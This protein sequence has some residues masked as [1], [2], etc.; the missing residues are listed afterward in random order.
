MTDVLA[1]VDAA[2]GALI[3]DATLSGEELHLVLGGCYLRLRSNSGAL[4]EHLRGYFG[5][6]L[7]PARDPDLDVLAIEREAPELEM[8]FIDWA[9]EPGK[10]GRKDSY[11]D[12]PGGRLIRKV[13]TGMVFL[14][15]ESRR[16]AAGPCN[17]YDNQ[18][19]NF[20]NAQYMNWLQHRG[21]RIC[22][23]A[24]LVHRGSCLGIAGFSGGGKSTL[25][26]RLLDDAGVNYL[27]N[28]R[29]FIRSDGEQV[30]AVG[31]PKLPRVN[32]GTIVHNPC[33]QALI[34]A[35]QRDEL[36]A[37]PAAQLWELEEKYD[38]LVEDLYGAGR[39]TPQAPL[40]AFLVLN[41]QRGSDRPLEVQPVDLDERRDLLAAIMKSPGP[42]YQYPDG[43]FY[44]DTTRL[45]EEAYLAALEGVSL[46]EAS[47]GVDFDALQSY[48]LNELMSDW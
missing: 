16:V 43:T 36:L 32:P 39:I 11:R 26:L 19:I 8:D 12:L 14:Q 44:R 48:C 6:V 18:V 17:K 13:R 37:L 24:G 10:T 3:G 7:G 35:A 45:D 9:R 42:F 22:H 23:A 21:W 15:S 1:S 33:L 2:A 4:V 34:P 29:L 27:T 47:G 46:Y 30:Q 40:A 5:H 38:V 31:I 25:M 28:D 41:W 20:V